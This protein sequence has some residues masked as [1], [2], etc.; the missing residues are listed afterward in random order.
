MIPF[1][2]YYNAI[3]ETLLAKDQRKVLHNIIR[4]C[5]K[6]IIMKNIMNVALI[7]ITSILE[8][9]LC[10]TFHLSHSRVKSEDLTI[11]P[12]F[13]VPTMSL[14]FEVNYSKD[15]RLGRKFMWEIF[16][17]LHLQIA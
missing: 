12:D 1:Y 17:F 14:K 8:K 2:V 10:A 13:Q 11:D 9:Y 5:Y 4:H 16:A 6:K 15:F 7:R 3:R